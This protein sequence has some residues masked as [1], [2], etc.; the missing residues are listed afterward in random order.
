MMQ[1][2]SSKSMTRVR[3]NHRAQDI[4]ESQALLLELG[5][6]EPTL[7]QCFKIIESTCLSQ[8]IYCSV[9][10]TEVTSEFQKFLDQHYMPCL[11]YTSPSPRDLSTSRM[12]SS[13]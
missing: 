3:A 1:D 9:D 5:T 12:P 4:A 10:G 7:Q 2:L 11:L 6:N 13:A 8:G